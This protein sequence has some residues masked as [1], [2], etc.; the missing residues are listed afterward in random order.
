MRSRRSYAVATLVVLLGACSGDQPGAGSPPASSSN[1]DSA[2]PG[3][4]SATDGEPQEAGVKPADGGDASDDAVASDA[5]DAG[6]G[7][8]PFGAPGE[9]ITVSAC[10][11]LTGHTSFPGYCPGP[12]DIECCIV[13]PSTANNPPV[14]TGYVLMQ[15]SQVTSAMTTWAVAILDDPTMYPM[16]ST[17]TMAFGALTVLARVEWHP[18]DFNNS[19]VHRGVTLYVPG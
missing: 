11:A 18:P 7:C 19:A 14:P 8:A 15:Q 13:T 1:A 3:D 9:C 10:A 6:D 2:A 12:A 5:G 17:T 16:F 4:A